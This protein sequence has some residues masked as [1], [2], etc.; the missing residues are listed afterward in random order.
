M[1]ATIEIL[2]RTE[3]IVNGTRRVKRCP[4]APESLECRWPLR[5]K[6]RDMNRKKK[7]R[8]CDGSG[9]IWLDGKEPE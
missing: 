2:S 4:D 6:M 3:G 8:H 5:D 9:I 1:S 7:C